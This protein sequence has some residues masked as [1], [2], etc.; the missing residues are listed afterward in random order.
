MG[1]RTLK[2][3]N[4]SCSDISTFI[5][6]LLAMKTLDFHPTSWPEP[7]ISASDRLLPSS[8]DGIAK[9]YQPLPGKKGLGF[10]I[11]EVWMLRPAAATAVAT[12]SGS[13]NATQARLDVE[14]SEAL[15]AK[16]M[17]FFQHFEEPNF[18]CVLI[19]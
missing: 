1:K 6:R 12:T 15:E 19:I 5:L 4:T 9:L 13:V 16:N 7:H 18:P 2:E 11:S 17:G 10:S 8:D 14:A 3:E